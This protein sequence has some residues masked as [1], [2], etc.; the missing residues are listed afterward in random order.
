MH[1]SC[2]AHSIQMASSLI[3]DRR[4]IYAAIQQRE[5]HKARKLVVGAESRAARFK[6]LFPSDLRIDYESTNS[7]ELMYNFYMN[8]LGNYFKDKWSVYRLSPLKTLDVTD[9]DT[10]Q[11]TNHK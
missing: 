8:H 6:S 4:S 10:E 5:D 7:R 9:P 2:Q 3:L 1:K 11:L